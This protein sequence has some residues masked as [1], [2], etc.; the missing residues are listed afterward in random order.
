MGNGNRGVSVF[1]VI[2]GFLITSLLLKEEQRKGCISL[3]D[4]YVRRALRILPPFYVFLVCLVLA[5][6]LGLINTNWRSLGISFGFIRDYF[7]GD[8][9]TG[10]SWSLSCGRTVLPSLADDPCTPG[11]ILG[12][13]DRAVSDRC[14]SYL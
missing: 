7:G 3:G 13:A 6:K 12:E 14:G 10:H 5:W 8:W 11:K 2:S 1:F 4:F 9:W